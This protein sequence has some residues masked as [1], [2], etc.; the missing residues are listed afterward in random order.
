MR[1]IKGQVG[2]GMLR[3]G[4]NEKNPTLSNV[5]FSKALPIMAMGT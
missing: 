1:P 5:G 4:L 3:D 2:K